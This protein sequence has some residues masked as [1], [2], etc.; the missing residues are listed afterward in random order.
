[1]VEEKIIALLTCRLNETPETCCNPVLDQMS[2]NRITW[3]CDLDTEEEEDDED[4]I[5]AD[6]LDLFVEASIGSVDRR[7]QPVVH[8]DKTI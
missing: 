1:M 5:V 4:E 2:L 7:D 6:E 8:S 3:F